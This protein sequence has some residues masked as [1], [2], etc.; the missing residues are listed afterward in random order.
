MLKIVKINTSNNNETPNSLDLLKSVE[1]W[2][3]VS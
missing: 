1:I 2:F 3:S